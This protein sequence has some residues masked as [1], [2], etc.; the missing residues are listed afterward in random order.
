M[1]TLTMV[2]PGFG[3]DAQAKNLLP[4]MER[5]ALR[6]AR[7]PECQDHTARILQG[8]DH[9]DVKAVAK[10]LDEW[11][12]K[13]IQYSANPVTGQVL[14][15]PKYV[16]SA[17]EAPCVSATAVA[18]I[19]LAAGQT[20]RFVLWGPKSMYTHVFAELYSPKDDRW[21]LADWVAPRSKLNDL[22]TGHRF[23]RRIKL[24]RKADNDENRVFVK[25]ACG[26]QVDAKIGRVGTP[27]PDADGLPP[28]TRV[29]IPPGLTQSFWESYLDRLGYGLRDVMRVVAEQATVGVREGIKAAAQGIAD[30]MQLQN[31]A[32]PSA[33]VV[34]GA[35]VVGIVLDR[36]ILS[37][38]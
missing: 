32:W 21:Y 1:P 35:L 23:T 17:K 28:G 38:R 30:G 15:T 33:V 31:R 16:L 3:S 9:R 25:C 24:N 13:H 5:E 20:V 6:Y 26:E 2:N 22:T 19:A 18:A 4:W 11:F 34:G 27:L 14:V 12:R 36:W 37:Q 7:T 10:R 8:I 29:V